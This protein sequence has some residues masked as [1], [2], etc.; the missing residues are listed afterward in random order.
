MKYVPRELPAE[1]NVTA[2]HP[3]VN[4]AHL[5]GTVL[6]ISIGVYLGLGLV[7]DQLVTRL[8]PE[9]EQNI[10]RALLPAQRSPDDHRIGYLND[11]INTFPR[12][13]EPD[14]LPLVVHVLNHELPN[15]GVLPG[16]QVIVTTGL[17]EAVDSE[18][19]LAFVL[20][21]ELGHHEVRDPLRGLGRSL[22]FLSMASVLGLGTAQ[23]G[24]LPD[25]V[26]LTGNLTALHYSRQQELAA[27]QYAL[28]AVVQKYQHGGHS[29]DFFERI[30]K[31]EAEM[32]YPGSNIELF[33][34]HPV[35]ADRLQTLQQYA[36]SQKWP[37]EGDATPLP[38]VLE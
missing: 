13:R 22:V 24:G 7:A 16:G 23:S 25:I 18:N 19:E 9:T 32:S 6:A 30:Q 28:S 33:S 36:A 8:S 4:F 21:H 10:G 12:S 15:A 5:L 29:L 3:L 2:V 11:L 1:V 14:R 37:M 20:A 27:D 35:T 31:L 26:P 17:L 38:A 34:T